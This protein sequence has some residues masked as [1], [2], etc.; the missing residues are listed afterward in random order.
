MLVVYSQVGEVLEP[1]KDIREPLSIC[2][3]LHLATGT[4]GTLL[5]PCVRHLR[6]VTTVGRIG[7]ILGI[8]RL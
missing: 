4:V 8:S 5:K 7:V 1:S 6:R 3:E 2:T